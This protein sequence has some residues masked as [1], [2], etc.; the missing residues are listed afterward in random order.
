MALTAEVPHFDFP[1]T[2]T[3]ARHA[4]VE[5]QDSLDDVI[6]CILVALLVEP[7]S[8]VEVSDFGVPDQVFENQPLNLPL[9]IS[10]VE[11]YEQRAEQ[12]MSQA[13]DR[14]DPLIARIQ[15]IVSLRSSTGRT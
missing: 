4:G 9:I 2:F 15:D 8:R 10:S 6:N 11:L 1:F 13:P 3:T 14:L 5:E 12:T 7:G